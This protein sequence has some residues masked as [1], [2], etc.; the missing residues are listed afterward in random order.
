MQDCDHLMPVRDVR[1]CAD[2]FFKVVEKRAF[3]ARNGLG[4]YAAG[5]RLVEF[6]GGN[7]RRAL[8]GNIRTVTPAQ[9]VSS[10]VRR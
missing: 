8:E 10:K 3:K 2:G 6:M 5:A 7:E 9:N 1:R 4:L